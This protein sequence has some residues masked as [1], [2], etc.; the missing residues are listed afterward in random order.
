MNR[1]KQQEGGIVSDVYDTERKYRKTPQRE[2]DMIGVYDTTINTKLFSTNYFLYNP[3][4]RLLEMLFTEFFE[5]EYHGVHIH[6]H[7]EFVLLNPF[8]ILQSKVESV[9]ISLHQINIRL[10]AL[11]QKC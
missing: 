5:I 7:P 10:P 11:S 1:G 3:T 8:G 4:K 6:F 9:S 2:M